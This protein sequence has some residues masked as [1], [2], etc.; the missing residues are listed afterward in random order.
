M[1][2]C[3]GLA[4]LLVAMVAFSGIAMAEKEEMILRDGVTGYV[5]VLETKKD[6]VKIAF[7]KDGADVT[8][9]LNA[10]KIDPHC[11]YTVRSKNMER[12]AANHFDLG[13]FCAENGLYN[14]A[15][16]QF[17][18]AKSIDPD[19]VAKQAAVPGLR[20]GVG[21][22]ILARAEEFFDAGKLDKAEEEVHLILTHLADTEAAD[23]ARALLTIIDK[24]GVELEEEEDAAAIAK[25]DAEKQKE[26]DALM[27]KLK[28]ARMSYEYAKELA[29][30]GLK[31]KSQSK[32]KKAFDAAG[33]EFEKALKKARAVIEKEK[34]EDV[35]GRWAAA[36]KRIMAEAVGAYIDAGRI[37]LARGSYVEAGNYARKALLV[38]P[39]SAAAKDFQNRVETGAAMGTEWGAAGINRV[40]GRG[41]GGGRR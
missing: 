9:V 26:A 7:K 33:E 37:E 31:E 29:A 1:N 22:K 11:F 13:I 28:P 2:R 4:A 35:A 17:E 34:V 19:F 24:R 32:A 21:R 6:S 8:L 15:M 25:L 16:H 38:D 36:E 10:D 27:K 20:E 23:D 39:T 3:I 18:V 14:R 41:P 12:T 5:N 40:G 30:R